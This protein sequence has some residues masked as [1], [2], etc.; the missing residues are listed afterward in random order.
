M[1]HEHEEVEQIPWAMLADQLEGPVIGRHVI[2]GTGAK[3]LGPVTVGARARIGA[4]RAGILMSFLPKD[5][6]AMVAALKPMALRS[7]RSFSVA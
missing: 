4:L 2:V 6:P 7:S 1:E 5:R 3:V